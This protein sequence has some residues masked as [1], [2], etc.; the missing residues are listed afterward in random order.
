MVNLMPARDIAGLQGRFLQIAFSRCFEG[1]AGYLLALVAVALVFAVRLA[2]LGVLD[3]RAALILF[4]PAILVASIAGGMGPSI[5][6]V[7]LSVL[8]ALYVGSVEGGTW[9]QL[10][11]FAIVGVAIAWMGEMLH[12][13]RRA[14]DRTEAALDA[15]EAH[16]RSILDTVLDATVVIEP[17]GS[18]V[19]FNATAVRQFGYAEAE[20]VGK[21]VHILMPEPYHRKKA[22]LSMGDMKNFRIG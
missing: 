21:N 2:L 1:Y 5:A 17:S 7:A 11:I 22:S 14:I 20:V 9:M 16:L 18:I 12:H 19:S 3:N 6:A 4:V 8:G 13:A 15:R 10:V